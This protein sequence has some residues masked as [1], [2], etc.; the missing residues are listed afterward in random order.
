MELAKHMFG[1]SE[2]KSSDGY[3][4]FSIKGRLPIFIYE[5]V[6]QRL[7]IYRTAPFHKAFS[8]MRK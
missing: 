4:M 7:N 3:S 6:F 5:L 2:R 1:S 8:H